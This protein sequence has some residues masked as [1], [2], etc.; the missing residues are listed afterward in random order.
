MIFTLSPV[1]ATEG[2]GEAILPLAAAKRQIKVEI[3]DDDQL[4]AVLRD[5]AIGFVEQYTNVRLG[6][7]EDMVAS[8]AGF[9]SAMR[10]GVGPAATVEITAVSYIN[11]DGD[12]MDM[13]E[14]EWRLGV[15]GS[16][17]PALNTCWPSG[18]GIVTVTFD[19]G[20][21]DDDRPAALVQ[22]AAL[23]LG[24]LYRNR[25]AVMETGMDGAIPTN[26]AWLCDRY[27]L[28]VM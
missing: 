19:A 25:E 21:T 13:D 3:D 15:D 10:L 18:A 16:L 22:A 5:A 24:Y 27:R 7:S 14:D 12:S 4:I 28:P 9:C 23:F 2:Y 20:Y 8:F 11:S 1:A 26:V 6:R 17:L